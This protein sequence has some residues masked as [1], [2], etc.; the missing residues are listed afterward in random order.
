MLIAF[1]GI[2]GSGKS[3]HMNNLKEYIENNTEFKVA[4]TSWNS[5]PSVE[6]L[7]I[8]L[9][10]KEHLN[11][12]SSSLIHALD[13]NLRYE[14]FIKP[15]LEQNYIVLADRY[16][17]TAY[18]RDQLRKIPKEMLDNMYNYACTPDIVFY[19][20]I[21]PL[22]AVKRQGN[23]I[24]ERTSYILGLDLKLAQDPIDNF[25][26]FLEM[27][28]NEYKK[29]INANKDT[30]YT[31]DALKDG[32]CQTQEIIDHFI[33]KCNEKKKELASKGIKP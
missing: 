6:Q 31:I 1:E 3:T 20:D 7:N 18:V 9:K 10:T 4:I 13:F 14:Y 19:F 8:E 25:K 29:I 30:F 15:M 22:D 33:N 27:Q 17:Y 32:Q 12:L 26:I 5:Y 24:Y 16:I 11:A 23:K 28:V 21:N 2:H